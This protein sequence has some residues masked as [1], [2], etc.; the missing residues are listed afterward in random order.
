MMEDGEAPTRS[1]G[2]A[3]SCGLSKR[4]VCQDKATLIFPLEKSFICMIIIILYNLE[5]YLFIY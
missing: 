1:R 4:F 3:L 2:K 5:I